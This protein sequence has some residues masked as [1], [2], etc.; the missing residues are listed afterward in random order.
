VQ[1]TFA[2]ICYLIAALII[3]VMCSVSLCCWCYRRKAARE[4]QEAYR[5]NMGAYQ[6]VPAAAPGQPAMVPV[7]QRDANGKVT[8][9]M[10][11]AVAQQQQSSTDPSTSR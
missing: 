9:V 7:A 10:V 2:Q 11:P 4:Q 6:P 8:Y 5:R 1:I 3:I